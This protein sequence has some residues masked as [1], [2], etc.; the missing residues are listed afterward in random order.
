[1][2]TAIKDSADQIAHDLTS[3]ELGIDNALAHSSALLQSMVLARAE[4]G[5]PFATGHT[6]ILRLVKALSSLTAARTDM[7]RIHADLRKI[8]EERADLIFPDECPNGVLDQHET[9]PSIRLVA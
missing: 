1:M 2:F 5:M 6:A 4:T 8:G 7:V 9:Q 3:S